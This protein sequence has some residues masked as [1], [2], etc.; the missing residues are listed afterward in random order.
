MRIAVAS[1]D[2]ITIAEHFGRCAGFEIY[3]IVENSQQSRK[4]NQHQQ[5]SSWSERMRRSQTWQDKSW[6][7]FFPID[8]QRLPGCDLPRNGKASNCRFVGKGNKAGNN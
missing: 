4:K 7:R 5:P 2:G 3:D 1:D 6:S 8:S